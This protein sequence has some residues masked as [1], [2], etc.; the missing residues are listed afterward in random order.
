[1]GCGGCELWSPANVIIA[2]IC[3]TIS[4]CN[5]DG[6]SVRSTV[7]SLMRGQ[8]TSDI[9]RSRQSIVVALS[10]KLRLGAA[11]SEAVEDV[12]RK[13]C[14]CYAGL[15][16][17][18]R[19]G[20][21]GYADAFEVPKLFP[22]RMAE[23]ANWGPPTAAEIQE[24]PWLRGMP[25]I[26]FISDMG[27]ALSH[28]VPFEYLDQEIIGAVSSPA[29]ERHVWLWLSKRPEVMAEFGEWLLSHG[30]YWPTNLVPMT[31]VTSQRYAGRVDALRRVPAKWRGLSL[32]PLLGP[33]DL[34]LKGITW[35]IAGG[36]SDILAEGFVAEQALDIYQQ[37]AEL[38]IAFFMKQLGRVPYFHT[39]LELADTHGGD[40]NEWPEVL[41]VREMPQ[42]IYKWGQGIS[43]AESL[44]RTKR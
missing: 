3:S 43:V 27:D 6:P 17:T 36:G 9:Y 23:A 33:L 39:A 30:G 35:V 12:I 28:G 5:H 11:M 42:E 22:G 18:Q 2:D 15:L 44:I 29:G 1:M 40:W 31:T 34:D 38:G 16:G 24:K 21:P 13:H 26:I 32:E 41:R 7:A 10:Q 8:L 4:I 25:R 20:H 37:C 19:A 14:A